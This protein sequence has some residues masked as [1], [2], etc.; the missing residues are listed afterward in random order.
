[1]AGKAETISLARLSQIRGVEESISCPRTALAPWRH[2]LGPTHGLTPSTCKGSAML[3]MW[4]LR[5]RLRHDC[6]RAPYTSGACRVGAVSAS[7][8]ELRNAALPRLKERLGSRGDPHD[9]RRGFPDQW[10]P[11]GVAEAKGSTATRRRMNEGLLEP[12][13]RLKTDRPLSTRNA[14]GPHSNTFTP[15]A[16]FRQ[17]FRRD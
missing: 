7:E 5:L 2:F 10:Q 17:R 1:M 4:P 12:L 14:D 15:R 6:G 13:G 11:V 9:H 3:C 8:Q 16:R